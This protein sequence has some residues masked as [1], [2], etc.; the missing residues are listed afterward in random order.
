MLPY[1]QIAPERRTIM[2]DNISDHNGVL[3]VALAQWAARDDTTADPGARMAANTAMDA[4]DAMLRELHALRS[5]LADEIRVS[6][7]ATAARVDAL[8]AELAAQDHRGATPAGLAGAE[9]DT[10]LRARHQLLVS[11]GDRRAR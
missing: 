7:D 1:D 4:I 11:H 5:R 2:E 10:R 3:G 6:D 8:L 9:A